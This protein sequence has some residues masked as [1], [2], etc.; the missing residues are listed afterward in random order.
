MVTEAITTYTWLTRSSIWCEAAVPVPLHA[1]WLKVVVFRRTSC[2]W[3]TAT[4]DRDQHR[5]TIGS[6]SGNANPTVFLCDLR[7]LFGRTAASDADGASYLLRCRPGWV[8]SVAM[9]AKHATRPLIRCGPWQSR[10]T[11]GAMGENYDDERDRSK[12]DE[13]IAAVR[14]GFSENTA[15]PLSQGFHTSLA[16]RHVIGH[17]LQSP[18]HFKLLRK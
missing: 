12:G 5:A 8:E 17:H 7:C 6:K 4:S 13:P 16:Q 3:P 18:L 1:A 9:A 10:G 15:E 14:L 2:M 11:V